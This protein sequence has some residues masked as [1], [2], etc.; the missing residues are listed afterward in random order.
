MD[1]KV[2]TTWSWIPLQLEY[3]QHKWA[4]SDKN[5]GEWIMWTRAECK[6]NFIMNS[7]QKREAR[8][9]KIGTFHSCRHHQRMKWTC[10]VIQ[11]IDHIWKWEWFT[12][13]IHVLYGHQNDG[14]GGDGDFSSVNLT[15]ANSTYRWHQENIDIFQWQWYSRF[16]ADFSMFCV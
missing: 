7:R 14:F 1:V 11:A 5:D 9:I 3:K 15:F 13:H 12:K 6:F 16:H 10:R 8:K 2:F 4:A